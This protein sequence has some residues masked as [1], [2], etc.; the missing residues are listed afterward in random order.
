MRRTGDVM[1]AARTAPVLP[2]RP[3]RQRVWP[4][5]G[6]A[7]GTLQYRK[8]TSRKLGSGPA[9]PLTMVPNGHTVQAQLPRTSESV[10]SARTLDSRGDAW[11]TTACVPTNAR[12]PEVCMTLSPRLPRCCWLAVALLSLLAL[13]PTPVAAQAIYGTVTGTVDRRLRRGGARRHRVA[14]QRGTGLRLEGVTDETGTY[15]VRNVTAGPY[16]LARLAAGLQGVRADGHPG[17][18]RR[19][20]PHQRQ[21]RDR[22]ADRVGHGH[23]RGGAAQDRQGRRER[24][25]AARGRRQPAAQPVPQLPGPDEP[26]ARAPRRRRSRTRRPT[27]LAARSRPTST[28]RRATT[29]RRASTARPAST[30][31][32]RTTRATSR[33]PRRSR[34]STSRPTTSTPPR[35]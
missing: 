20:R 24:R 21:A 26:G 5:D 10:G 7:R 27:R 4:D 13:L 16:T 32:C 17:H 3:R 25:P 29:T 6:R 19:H 11:P 22:R 15:T 2:G 14:R 12:L 18:G 9:R 35:A 1:G 23:H 31:G 34:T 28:A 30:S 33:R 8:R